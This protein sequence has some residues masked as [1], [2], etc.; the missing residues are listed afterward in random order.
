MMGRVNTGRM[1]RFMA[2]T[3]IWVPRLEPSLMVMPAVRYG[4]LRSRHHLT[5][6][7]VLDGRG[8]AARTDIRC[9][10]LSA[11]R[12]REHAVSCKSLLPIYRPLSNQIVLP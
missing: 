4:G 9:I 1:Y 7:S 6:P 5:Q 2:Q 10:E 3:M 8:R 11:V 12:F